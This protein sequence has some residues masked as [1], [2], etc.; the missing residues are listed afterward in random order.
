MSAL[1]IR[2][3]ELATGRT[4]DVRIRRGCIDELGVALEPAPGELCLEAG[5]GA[6]L[7][8]LHDH[9]LHLL[10]LAAARDSLPCGPPKVHSRQELID[11]LRAV[12]NASTERGPHSGWLRG[13]GYHE[14]VAGR[15][16]RWKLDEWVSDRPL[17][18]QHRSGALW[19]LNS[20]AVR[21]L[22]L[23]HGELPSGAERDARGRV[24]GRL[25]RLDEWLGARLPATPP[26]S[27]KHVGRQFAR[28]GVTGL[29]DAGACNSEAELRCLIAAAESGD[30]PQKLLVMGKPDLPPSSHPRVTRGHVKLML[31]EDHL[32]AIDELTAVIQRAHA[33]GRGA[34]LHCVTRAEL[35]LAAVALS[36]AGCQRDDRIE[37]ASVAPPDIVTLLARLPVAV[38]TQPNFIFERGDAYRREVEP[39]DQ[40]WLYRCRGFLA[41][42]LPLA[43]G[44]DAPFGEPDPWAAMRAAVVRRSAAG[45]ELGSREALTPEQALALF[46]SPLSA[47]GGAPARLQPGSPADL[48]LLDRPWSAAR[49]E[50][51]A[52]AVLTTLRDGEII[53]RRDE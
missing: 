6:L 28:L 50:L 3:A 13:L 29:C 10:A 33:D 51:T 8:G 49:E 23:E 19:M 25:F 4:L 31:D 27:L 11:A 35:V 22:G 47:P 1:L 42:G 9:H 40:P 38:V 2:Q 5:G 21:Q 26:P 46:T 43:A 20:A 17:R 30:L 52:D 24:T 34:A 37:H 32:P 15:L 41:A 7:P 44:S 16:D 53:W 36:S 39:H 14:S 12:E 45:F 48:C 18:I